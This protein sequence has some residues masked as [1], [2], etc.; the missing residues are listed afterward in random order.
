MT[1]VAVNK[2]VGAEDEDVEGASSAS[3]SLNENEFLNM[4]AEIEWQP[5]IRYLQPAEVAVNRF[6]YISQPRSVAEIRENISAARFLPKAFIHRTAVHIPPVFRGRIEKIQVK[7][8]RKGAVG[9]ILM[10][11]GTPEEF[12]AQ[13]SDLV[14]RKLLRAVSMAERLEA[15]LIGV[16]TAS[17]E[18]SDAISTIAPKTIVPLCSGQA[19]TIY[20]TLASGV[21]I[22]TQNSVR[23]AGPLKGVVINAADPLVAVA[24]E[25]LASMIPTITLIGSEPDLLIAL[26]RK[27]EDIHA[28]TKIEIATDPNEAIRT[29]DLIVLGRNAAGRRMTFNPDLCNPGAVLCDFSQPT[30]IT[31]ELLAQRPDLTLIE[32][33]IF[34]LPE[35]PTGMACGNLPHGLVT[36]AF[37]EAA[38]L[39]IRG[40]FVDFGLAGQLSSKNV[41]DI[42]DLALL[43]NVVRAGVVANGEVV[44]QALLEA[45]KRLAERYTVPAETTGGAIEAAELDFAVQPTR[46]SVRRFAKEHSAVVVTGVGVVAVLAGVL[47]WFFRKRKKSEKV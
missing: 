4:L 24:A 38:L 7:G 22:A 43:S 32:S 36:S 1:A 47:G 5:S 11:G 45:R 34:R 41:Y 20:G 16:D 14:A 28:K 40:N 42:R 17:R 27:I 18:V 23:S 6:G 30:V 2:H 9:E 37:A 21:E 35:N 25:V 12:A 46:P 10:L 8:S 33:A 39:A 31:P 29:S 13:E 44:P 26:K 19:M 15:R 3:L